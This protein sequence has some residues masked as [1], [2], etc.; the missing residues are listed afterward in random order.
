MYY[1]CSNSFKDKTEDGW[2]VTR[3]KTKVCFCD[4]DHDGDGYDDNDNDD[5]YSDES[6]LMI[7]RPTMWHCVT[8]AVLTHDVMYTRFSFWNPPKSALGKDGVSK[9]D[10]FSEKFQKGGGVISNPKIYVADFG[11]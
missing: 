3:A 9:T 1:S 4:D 7:P 6:S 8:G 10:E 5:D 11:P 2:V